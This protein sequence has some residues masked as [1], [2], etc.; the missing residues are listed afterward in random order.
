MCISERKSKCRRMLVRIADTLT[1]HEQHRVH[2]E[3][4][5]RRSAV[6]P[7]HIVRTEHRHRI[8]GD[9]AVDLGLVVDETLRTRDAPQSPAHLTADARAVESLGATALVE[10]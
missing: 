9:Q 5:E 3:H 6:E 1:S 8:G 7:A 2:A 10:V 4:C